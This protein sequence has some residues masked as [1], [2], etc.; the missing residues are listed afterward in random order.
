M[1]NFLDKIKREIEAL[2]R[3][4]MKFK[5]EVKKRE[6]ITK[7]IRKLKYLKPNNGGP[8]DHRKHILEDRDKNYRDR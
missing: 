3:D 6:A 7:N 5:K 8:N 4:L 1:E 2:E